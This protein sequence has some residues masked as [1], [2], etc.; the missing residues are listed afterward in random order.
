MKR[1]PNV[2]VLVL[3]SLRAES[4]SLYGHPIPTT[5][6]IDALATSGTVYENAISS[7]LWTIPSHA[8]MLSGLYPSQHCITNMQGTRRFNSQLVTL[9]EALRREGYVTAAF[10][11]NPFFAPSYGLG[12]GFSAFFETNDPA[13]N[14]ACAAIG[15][16][17]RSDIGFLHRTGFFLERLRAPQNCLQMILRWMRTHAGRE[18]PV[19]AFA[20]L[21]A[22]HF[23]WIVPPHIL[24]RAKAFDLR[25][26][27]RADYVTL[28]REWEFNSRAATP[29]KAHLRMW[30]KLYDAAIMHV[31]AAVGRFVDH[32]AG[33]PGW[34][35]TILVVTSD[36]GE[37]LGDYRGIVGHSLTMS[38]KLIRV[39]I[40]VRHP[41][42]NEGDRV[43]GVVQTV[44]LYRT[45]LDWTGTSLNAVPSAQT[46]MPSLDTP[47]HGRTAVT[48]E[49]YTDGFDVLS[50]LKTLNPALDD[51]FYPWAQKS[52]R[53]RS[54]KYVAYETG[55]GEFYDLSVDPHERC[56]LIA[57]V[58]SEQLVPL[59]ELQRALAVWH[60]DREVFPPVQLERSTDRS[61]EV[62]ERLRALGY[63]S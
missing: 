55:P 6:R 57:S 2:I 27:S 29:S 22:P 16:L 30:R 50:R 44:D 8:S 37:V 9:P 39:P 13:G 7:A 63:L 59:R 33:W 31:D 54:H 36:H 42:R 46:E 23:P 25:Y 19:F 51:D 4:M 35:N 47:L 12:D 17:V 60:T 24:I 62:E 32:A 38:D 34:T 43:S 5:P 40:V 11:Q 21:L 48:E 61:S 1:R 52:V 26:L 10:S 45:I 58:D 3:D 41:D 14:H 18:R 20:N 28:T 49:D 53:S 15:R 56:N